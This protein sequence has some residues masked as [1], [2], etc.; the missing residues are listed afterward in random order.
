MQIG[1]EEEEALNTLN[2][3]VGIFYWIIRIRA[4]MKRRFRFSIIDKV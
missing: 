2:N 1:G 4:I 3:H